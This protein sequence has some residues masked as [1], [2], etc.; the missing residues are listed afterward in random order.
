[1]GP[2][3]I[4]EVTDH[5]GRVTARMPLPEAGLDIGRGYRNGLVLDDPYVDA[6]HLRVSAAEDGTLRF[7]DAGTTNGTWDS[8]RHHRLPS[9]AVVPG[10]ELRIGRSVVRFVSA[11]QEVPPALFDPAGHAQVRWLLAPQRVAAVLVG[12]V[13]L[14]G[15]L[16]YLGSWTDESVAALLQPGMAAL[17]VGALWAAGWAFTNRIV[18]QRFRFLPHLA[19]AAVIGAGYALMA[20][21][22]EWFWF[23]TPGFGWT[24]VTGF[25]SMGLFA[26]LLAGHFQLVT[27]WPNRRTWITAIATTVG[28]AVI[29]VVLAR[30]TDSSGTGPSDIGP[31]KPVDAG[32][33]PATTFDEFFAEASR[34]RTEVDDLAGT[35]EPGASAADSTAE[36]PK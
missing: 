13:L 15:V 29:A 14:S 5:R 12:V 32:L 10:V 24:T 2:A 30:G 31:L 8:R 1:M 7:E 18:G 33:L 20:Q 19:W 3:L 26:W 25:F 34:L 11:D 22:V 21:A 35:D 28:L 17:L 9:G 16:H 4:V 27:E 36:A 6:R 23:A